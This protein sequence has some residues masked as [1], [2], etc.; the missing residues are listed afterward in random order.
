MLATALHQIRQHQQHQRHAAQ[1]DSVIPDLVVFDQPLPAETTLLPASGP[2]APLPNPA[3]SASAG[4]PPAPLPIPAASTLPLVPSGPQELAS[5]VSQMMAKFRERAGAPGE[6]PSRKRPA[7]ACN[8]KTKKT[9]KRNKKN[10]KKNKKKDDDSDD[11]SDEDEDS[12]EEKNAYVKPASKH[13]RGQPAPKTRLTPENGY[14]GPPPHPKKD[15]T[16]KYAAPR[17]MDPLYYGHST[18]YVDMTRKAWRLKLFQGDK[19]DRKFYW[20]S[21]PQGKWAE[22][23]AT[24]RKVNR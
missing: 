16:L 13:T 5:G 24:M 10:N 12:D 20:G 3:A 15:S 18:V 2:T 14:K 8:E 19:H 23:V 21:D 17:K 7:A 6:E 4:Y 11:D 1:A 22:V 9:Q